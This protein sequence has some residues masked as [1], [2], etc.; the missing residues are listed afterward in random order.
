MER[1]VVKMESDHQPRDTEKMTSNPTFFLF[2]FFF[3]CL[4]FPAFYPASFPSLSLPTQNIFSSNEVFLF[5]QGLHWSLKPQN[6]ECV[7]RTKNYQHYF[8]L[9]KIFCGKWRSNIRKGIL[10]LVQIC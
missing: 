6:T 5:L 1:V 4:A 7:F 2:H 9:I 8:F 10:F 3:F